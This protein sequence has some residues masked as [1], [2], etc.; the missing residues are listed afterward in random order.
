[1][2]HCSWYLLQ[3]GLVVWK[4]V[5]KQ[6]WPFGISDKYDCPSLVFI[7]KN[8][9]DIFHPINAHPKFL[10][11]F[12]SAESNPWKS[13]T[14]NLLPTK[15]FKTKGSFNNVTTFHFAQLN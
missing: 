10:L 8:I 6:V 1:M 13:V 15:L 4:I 5:T 7:I 12:V 3:A 9:I 11:F 14:P 2:F